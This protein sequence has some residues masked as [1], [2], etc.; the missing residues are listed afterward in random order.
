MLRRTKAII[1]HQLPKKRDNIVFCQ[2]APLQMKVYKRALQ[3][4]DVQ[5]LI[6]KA[7]EECPCGSGKFIY[8]CKGPECPKYWTLTYE[9]GKNSSLFNIKLHLKSPF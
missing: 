2:L 3:L 7:R 4:P 8:K 9:Q 1:A 6:L 5:N